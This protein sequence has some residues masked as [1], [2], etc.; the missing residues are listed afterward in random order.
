LEG[1]GANSWGEGKGGEV[2]HKGGKK[3][4][5]KAVKRARRVKEKQGTS[6]TRRGGGE[7]GAAA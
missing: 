4:L 6:D 5:C 2:V 1:E 7:Y 3:K